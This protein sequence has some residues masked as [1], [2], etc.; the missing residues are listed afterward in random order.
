VVDSGVV[1]CREKQKNKAKIGISDG[2]KKIR[3]I[4]ASY[5]PLLLASVFTRLLKHFRICKASNSSYKGKIVMRISLS[6]PASERASEN[7]CVF[8]PRRQLSK[9]DFGDLP[10]L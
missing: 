5:Q 7:Y 6:Q 1:A 9:I 8:P 10:F 3:Q 4:G 2:P